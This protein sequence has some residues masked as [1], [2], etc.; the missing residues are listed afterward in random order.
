MCGRYRDI[1][2]SSSHPSYWPGIF[3][4]AKKCIVYGK[5]DCWL[6]NHTQQERDQLKKKFDNCYPQ[7]KA[8]ASYEGNLER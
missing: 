3:Q 4:Y 6:S 2:S 8:Q 7:Y 1:F 5:V